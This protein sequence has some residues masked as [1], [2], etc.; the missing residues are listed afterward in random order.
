MEEQTLGTAING[1]QPA[2]S[3]GIVIV[4]NSN[5][6]YTPPEDAGKYLETWDNVYLDFRSQN[7]NIAIDDAYSGGGG[8]FGNVDDDNAISYIV[9]KVTENFYKSRVKISGYVNFFAP[10]IDAKVDPVFTMGVSDYI[11]TGEGD[12]RKKVEEDIWLDFVDNACAGKSLNEI[13]ESAAKS[14]EKHDVSYLV[15]DK[16]NGKTVMYT[17]SAS[18]VDEYVRNPRTQDLDGITFFETPEDAGDGSVIFVKHRWSIGQLEILKSDP[19]S[20]N[21][22]KETLDYKVDDTLSTGINILNVYPMFASPADIGDYK[23]SLPKSYK[24]AAMCNWLYNLFNQSGYVIFKQCHSLLVFQGETTGIR[25]PLSN[26]A[27]IPA[28]E[29]NGRSFSMPEMLSPDPDLPRV[30]IENIEKIIGY[31]ISTMGRTLKRA[32]KWVKSTFNLFNGRNDKSYDYVTT[33]P[34][35]FYPDRGMD[36]LEGMEIVKELE[37]RGLH[38][39]A[40]EVLKSIIGKMLKDAP[41]DTISGIMSQIEEYSEKLKELSLNDAVPNNGNDDDGEKEE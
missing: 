28:N 26:A 35:D 9:P 39:A 10:Y 40:S 4:D 38:T 41:L 31:M 25:D 8:F 6:P 11:F 22:D 18:V 5:R 2:D 15:M 1:T 37:D 12:S 30:H 7:I 20:P 24:I 14:A 29:P 21:T 34:E 17:K 33:Y 19:V 23:P 3:K 13:R 16:V 36:A 32:D 27:T